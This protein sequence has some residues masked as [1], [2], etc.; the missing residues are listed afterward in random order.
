MEP[1]EGRQTNLFVERQNFFRPTGFEVQKGPDAPEKIPGLCQS[2]KV[3]SGEKAAIC[4]VLQCCCLIPGH[5][6]PAD[7]MEVPHPSLTSFDVRLQEIHRLSELRIVTTALFN[8]LLDELFHPATD[9]FFR[10]SA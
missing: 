7:Q 1:I 2:E 10:I 5:A 3:L 6:S 8:L 4:Q 9:H